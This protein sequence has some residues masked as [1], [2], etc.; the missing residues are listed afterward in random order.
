MVDANEWRTNQD[1]TLLGEMIELAV[2]CIVVL[3][4][5]DLLD[6]IQ[7]EELKKTTTKLLTWAPWIPITTI[8][9][10]DGVGIEKVM[11]W[12]KKIHEWRD[13][14]ISTHK[15]ND[16]LK[17][18]WLA[19][20]PRFPK[21]KV[22]KFYYATQVEVKPLTVVLFINDIGKANYAFTRWVQ[23]VLRTAFG[24]DGVPIVIKFKDKEEDG[25]KW[26]TRKDRKDKEEDEEGEDIDTATK[27]IRGWKMWKKTSA[28]T[29]KPT[30]KPAIKLVMDEEE[31]VRSP[32][33]KPTR[34]DGHPLRRSRTAKKADKD[35]A[36]V[37]AKKVEKQTL[38][39][40]R[41][42][43]AIRAKRAKKK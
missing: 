5:V 36:F 20:P 19:N 32:R 35:K 25:Q 30:K 39:Q 11:R 40:E 4:K 28:T 31:Q 8:S 10:R 15:L 18:A 42:R 37:K 27:P 12:A 24:L 1:M 29:D 41:K 6:N 3:N 43:D 23:N 22:C 14:R 33:L 13:Q 17:K 2:P 34:K 38:N 9:A 7:L 21:N 26:E 16:T